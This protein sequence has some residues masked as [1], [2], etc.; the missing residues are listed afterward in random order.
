MSHNSDRKRKIESANGSTPNKQPK[1]FDL[2]DTRSSLP[3]YPMRESLVKAVQ[4][5]DS[6]ILL[7]ETGSGKTTQLPRFLYESG[8]F[9]T[10]TIAVTQPRRVAAI[11]VA[12]RVAVE[13]GVD[14]GSK[15]GYVVRF[16][17]HST[18]GQ[19][20]IK[21]MTDGMLLREA[22]LDP[23]LKKYS[24]VILDEA[25]ERTVQT[26]VLFG[27]VKAAQKA[28][29]CTDLS[30]SPLRVVVMSATMDVD[31]FANYFNAAPVLYVEG[32]QHKVDVKYAV[33]TQKDYVYASLVS[34]FQL[35]REA[36][37]NEAILI[38]LTGQEEIESVVA[39][40]K[41]L[42]QDPSN[43]L[44]KMEIVALY[45]SL[46][47][48]LQLRAFN[49][50][51]PNCRKVV[52]STNIA[53]TSVTIQGIRHVIDTGKVKAK[54]FN[55]TSGLDLLKVH[56]VSKAQAWQ[57]TGRAGR[58][59]SGT[60]YRLF[61]ENDY[62]SLPDSTVPE[63]QRC[64]LA[65]VLLSI[66][67]MGI[68]DVRHFDFI[69]RPSQESIDKAI[70]TL[71]LLGALNKTGESTT[72]SISE[73]GK[74]MSAFPLDPK[75][76]KVLLA[77]KTHRC[78]EEVLTIVAMLSTDSVFLSPAQKKD[79]AEASKI[80]FQSNEGDHITLLN[81]WRAYK[82][83]NQNKDW[84]YQNFINARN[85][86]NAAEIRAQLR[87]LCEQSNIPLIAC[88]RDNTAAIRKAFASGFFMNAAEL[89]PRD[90]REFQTL[91]PPKQTAII[92]PSSALFRAN[93][94]AVIYNELVKT[95][96]CYMRDVLVVDPAWLTELVPKKG[97]E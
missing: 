64:N 61:S 46:P 32:R 71:V 89:N 58:E 87:G 42:A 55:P 93:P 14:C 34:L 2:S 3:I 51:P 20:K 1:N 44:E 41:A 67:A 40:A 50:A 57:R 75:L 43:E 53:E 52:V 22:I 38:F 63:I 23:L 19:T 12:Q 45:A 77:S 70:E 18:P 28:R 80:K 6:L 21:Y 27:V 62:R 94:S 7:G 79:E 29:K 26:D 88:G 91:V 48:H 13:M 33:E 39:S 49:K 56:N 82:S 76:A 10:G 66:V 72:Y 96:K 59:A 95:N 60:C 78:S 83:S 35:H 74:Q 69:D 54:S 47:Q 84:C 36:P 90:P 97:K 85:M 15:V 92:H 73:A 65:S 4:E 25:H 68:K 16:D 5:N 9:K 24:V 37:L 11:T 8:S 17:D 31:H 86:R 81:V 30:L